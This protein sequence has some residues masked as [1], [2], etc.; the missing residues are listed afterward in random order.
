MTNELATDARSFFEQFDLELTDGPVADLPSSFDAF[1]KSL[2]V[3]ANAD[4]TAAQLHT[5]ATLRLWKLV[6][7]D[8]EGTIDK[9][10][11]S[12]DDLQKDKRRRYRS[13]SLVDAV[14][15]RGVLRA[16]NAPI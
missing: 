9:Q 13:R 2:I 10:L 4:Q 3:S 12:I 11:L 8:P 14:L 6:T 15:G 16:G 1:C 7:D 5:E